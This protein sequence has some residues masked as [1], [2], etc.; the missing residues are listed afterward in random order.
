[1][2]L[3]DQQV[4]TLILKALQGLKDDLGADG[5]F[6]VCSTTGLFGVNAAIDSLSLVSLIVD[7]ETTLNT[8]FNLSVSLT[9]DRAMTRPQSPFINVQTLKEYI[10]ELAG[11]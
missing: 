1:M 9:D 5:K 10:L 2:N 7:I 3:T 11:E 8:E 4:E 6:E